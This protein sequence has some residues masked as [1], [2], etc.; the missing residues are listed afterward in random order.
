M[1]VSI[2]PVRLRCV[3]PLRKLKRSVVE[4]LSAEEITNLSE[5]TLK[6]NFPHLIRYLSDRRCGMQL[7]DALAIADGKEVAA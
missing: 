6:R 1:T 2:D 4:G 5:D 3:V 7:G